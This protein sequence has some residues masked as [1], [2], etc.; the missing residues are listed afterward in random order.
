MFADR[1]LVL[2]HV[3]KGQFQQDTLCTYIVTF[4]RVRVTIV[5]V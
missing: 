1:M 2:W 5:A 3:G 4:R